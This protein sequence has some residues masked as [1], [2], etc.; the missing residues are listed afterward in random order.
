VWAPKYRNWVLQGAGRERVRELLCESAWPHGF[1]IEELE[2]DKDHVHLFL[3]FPPKSSIGAVVPVGKTVSLAPEIS[4]VVP[5]YVTV[6]ESSAI[7]TT[8]GILFQ[9]GVGILL[10]PASP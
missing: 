1:E 5:M 8:S 3:S 9:V 7:P 4:F 2:V 6:G 10:G